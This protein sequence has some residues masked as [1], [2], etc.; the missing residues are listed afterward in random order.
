MAKAS[1]CFALEGETHNPWGEKK[2]KKNRGKIETYAIGTGS[3]GQSHLQTAAQ[4]RDRIWG[5]LDRASKGGE[6]A[7]HVKASPHSRKKI[8]GG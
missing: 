1:H 4:E 5:R 3:R 8:F 7:T 2:K 6:R